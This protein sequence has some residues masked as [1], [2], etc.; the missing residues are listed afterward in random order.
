MEN[1]SGNKAFEYQWIHWIP[2][3]GKQNYLHLKRMENY[4]NALH[5]NFSLRSAN[6]WNHYMDYH[7]GLHI[8]DCGPV[9]ER[10]KAVG[11]DYFLVR[12]LMLFAVYVKDDTGIVYEFICP[13]I[14]MPAYD[15]ESY[16]SRFVNKVSRDVED[17]DFC[18]ERPSVA[19]EHGEVTI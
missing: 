7:P 14:S 3:S 11:I 2:Q 17:W 18:L 8:R 15:V 4:L 5:G 13:S 1:D 10:L 9:I 16:S 6:K 19:T 12:Q